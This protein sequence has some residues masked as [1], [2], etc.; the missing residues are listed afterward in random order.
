[1]SMDPPDMLIQIL[2]ARK[3]RSVIPLAVRNRT[4]QRV[5]GAAV[6]FVHFALVPEE[7]AG[8]GEAL[9]LATHGVCAAV[10]AVVLV[11]VFGPF[12]FAVEG[13]GL[14]AGAGT[15]HFAGGVA[16]RGGVFAGVEVR[17]GVGGGRGGMVVV[18]GGM[19]GELGVV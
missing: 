12:A 4:V 17:V 1:M 15:D 10:G 9:E 2:P 13:E 7:A 3:P 16:G 8:V 11:D 19:I 14:A 18:G 5:L 6:R